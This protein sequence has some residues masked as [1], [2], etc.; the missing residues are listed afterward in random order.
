MFKHKKASVSS[1]A[2]FE[3]FANE[4]FGN[5]FYVAAWNVFTVK[6]LYSIETFIGE[7]HANLKSNKPVQL[8]LKCPDKI[9]DTVIETFVLKLIICSHLMLSE[10]G[11]LVTSLMTSTSMIA[12]DSF[13]AVLSKRGHMEHWDSMRREISCEIISLSVSAP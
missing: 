1:D 12:Y 11:H 4:E 8:F 3:G 2:K 9:S 10:R 7:A 13:R 5:N 6:L